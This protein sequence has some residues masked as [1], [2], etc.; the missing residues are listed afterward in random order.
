M[1]HLAIDIGASSGR[2]VHGELE[3]GKIVLNEIHRFPNFFRE[4]H[5]HCFWNIDYLFEEIIK[6]LIKAKQNGISECTLGVDTW[7]VDYVL[8]DE[9]GNR[10]QDVYAYRDVR[11]EHTME[12][13]FNILPKETI[14]KKTG[15]QFLSFNTLFQL[16]EE[17][18]DVLARCK[19]ILLIPDYLN[20]L[21]TGKLTLEITNFSTT[22]LLNISTRQLD[23]DLL[24]IVN[25]KPSQ[26][27]TLIEPGIEIGPLLLSLTKQFDLP[28]VTV[29]S[30]ASH[31][32][33]SAVLGTPSISEH[34]AYLSSGTWSLVGIESNKPFVT[35]ETLHDNY[36]NE[37]GAF[38]TYRFLKNIMGLWIIQ[39]VQ[40]LLPETYTFTELVNLAKEVK[41]VQSFINLNE[42]RFLKPTNMIK[43]LQA[44]CKETNQPIP[45][46]AGEIA[47]CV[48]QN[49]AILIAFHL[50]HIEVTSTT[51]IDHLYIVGGGSNN[52]YLNELISNYTQKTVYAGPSEATAL[53]NLLIQFLHCKKIKTVKEGRQVIHNS[54]DI[55]KYESNTF[56]RETIFNLFFEKTLLIK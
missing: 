27:P 28:N 7:A 3:N 36:T 20:Y 41:E 31:D 12:K 5:G 50:E 19:H 47:A 16:F 39:E 40:R 18:Q 23:N 6:G 21:L 17:S 46:T 51:V 52:D 29:I 53:G 34:W 54:F 25:L 55:K 49:L 45:S 11:T 10:L 48:F 24:N 15:I 56:N 4:E 43:E 14:Y 33:A 42:Q 30:V 2:I 13:V 44:Y 38:H 1:H 8:L 9:Q 32:T 37:Y 22:Q 35:D 26:F